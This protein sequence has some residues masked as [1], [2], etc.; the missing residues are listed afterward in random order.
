MTSARESAIEELRGMAGRVA[1]DY[2]LEVFD[3]SFRRESSG[4][5]LRL[6]LDRTDGVEV[7][8]EDCQK[9]SRDFGTLVDVDDERFGAEGRPAVAH[10]AL[11]SVR[12]RSRA[13]SQSTKRAMGIVRTRKMSAVAT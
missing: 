7:G 8:I 13:M 5:V 10:R 11:A 9:V 2:G 12:R 3:L 6:I 1:A 4:W